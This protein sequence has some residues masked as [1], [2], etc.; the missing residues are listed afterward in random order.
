MNTELALIFRLIPTK[1]LTRTVIADGATACYEKA[2]DID[3]WVFGLN[4]DKKV[5]K[6]VLD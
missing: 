5:E 1:Y 2:N 6:F 3:I 4:D